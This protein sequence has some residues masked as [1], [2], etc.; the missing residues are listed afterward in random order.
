MLRE[1]VREAA[2]R[3][4]D[5]IAYDG[6]DGRL[7]YA[8]LDARSDAIAAGLASRG[9]GDRD[10]VVLRL[11]SGVGYLLAYV[12]VV[13][14][15]AACAGVNPKLAP[16]EQEVLVERVSPTLVIDEPTLADLTAEPAY[17][18]HLEGGI[19][20]HVRA[21]PPEV[22]PDPDRPVAIVFTSGTTGTPKG[23][24]FRERQLQAVSDIDIGPDAPWGGG[25]PMLVATQFPHIGFMTK[26]PWYLRTGSTLVALERWRADDVLAAVAAHRI[27]VIG[28]V[29]PQMALL[30]RSSR[31]DE[32][33]LDCVRQFVVGGSQ[34]SPALVR[35]I[36]ERFGA[37][38][39]IR[40]SST[41][42]GGVGLGTAFDA[43]DVEALHTIGRPR[44]GVE[45][46][47]TDTSDDGVG[48]LLVRSAAQLDSYWNDPEAT[49]A[50]IDADGWLHTGDLARIDDAG[51]F[52]LSGRLKEMYI[53]GGYNV[54]PAEIEAVLEDHPA[55]AELVVVA[56][57]DEVMGE[58]GIAV[59]RLTDGREPPTL[60]DLRTF[61]DG[62]LAAWKLP[63]DLL[64]VDDL[65][66]TPM[67]KI[68]RRA[69]AELASRRRA[70]RGTAVEEAPTKE[71]RA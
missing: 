52:C 45:A 53:R 61:A 25:P 48:E 21:V 59:L 11:P 1:T 50:A 10:V 44:P 23:A 66:R 6:W 54:F 41:E 51:R 8:E 63:E 4:G 55:V 17:E 46:R 42:S 36:R 39:S 2:A 14:V 43:D 30:L 33:D 7:T 15:G 26:L 27:P 32:L 60:D 47:V 3:F 22:A 57:P 64:V 9:V 29:A 19:P 40:Y 5:A 37:A 18:A 31:L 16:A 56:R 68:D 35:Q 28:G 49:A 38:Y 67:D 13:K 62:R 65:P 69:V 71:G 34:S 70:E 58:V 12:G 24:L 20:P